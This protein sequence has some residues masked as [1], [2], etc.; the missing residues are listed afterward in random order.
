MP[1]RG[2]ASVEDRSEE[3]TERN[4]VRAG[5]EVDVAGGEGTGAA[6]REGRQGGSARAQLRLPLPDLGRPDPAGL[7]WYGGLGALAVIGVLDWPVAV[8]IGAA[9]AIAARSSGDHSQP[10]EQ[11]R[12]RAA[13]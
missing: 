5:A 10:V 1:P 12:A 8:V 3:H 6:G 7:L 2:R 13:R 9:T 4:G 11:R